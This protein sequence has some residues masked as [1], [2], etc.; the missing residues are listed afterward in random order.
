MTEALINLAVDAMPMKFRESI[1]TEKDAT[2]IGEL[3]RFLHEKRRYK[4]DL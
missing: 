3:E 2:T 1:T 4:A